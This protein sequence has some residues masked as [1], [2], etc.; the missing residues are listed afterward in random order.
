MRY[1]I[2]ITRLLCNL[3]ILILY[4]FGAFTPQVM[5]YN[6]FR[7]LSKIIMHN[8]NNNCNGSTEIS[9][10]FKQVALNLKSNTT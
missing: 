8:V 1:K 9:I 3:V 2:K 4:N 7:F 5:N 10:I 6:H